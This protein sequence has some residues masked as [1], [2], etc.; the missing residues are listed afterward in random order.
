M[1]VVIWVETCGQCW[2]L[3]PVSS[4]VGFAL[5]TRHSVKPSGKVKGYDPGGIAVYGAGPPSLD[6][7]DRWFESRRSWV[8]CVCCIGS[9]LCEEPITR[10]EES[11]RLCVCLICVWP[12]NINR[13][14]VLTRFGLLDNKIKQRKIISIWLIPFHLMKA[15]VGVELQIHLFLSS[16]IYWVE[17]G[18]LYDLAPVPLSNCPQHS[19]DVKGWRSRLDTV[20][21]HTIADLAWYRRP[22]PCLFVP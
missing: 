17:H 11:Y 21:K 8:S 5:D 4:V 20:T 3:H 7:W 2:W 22:V 14:T 9:G 13:Q 10:P 19:L 18:Q 1:F 16:T 6:C 15:Y 12:V